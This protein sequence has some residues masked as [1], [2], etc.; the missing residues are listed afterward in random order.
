MQPRPDDPGSGDHRERGLFCGVD[1]GASATKVVLLDASAERV[2]RAVRPSG[3]DYHATASLCL[4]EALARLGASPSQLVRTVS[5]GYGRR[6]V[7]FA[8]ASLTEIHCHG[9]GCFRHLPRAITVIDIGGQDN[10]VIL[11]DAAGRRLDFKMNRKCAAGTGAFIEE[12]ALRLGLALEEMDGLAKTTSRAVQL[13]SFC[14]VFAKTEILA[15]LRAGVP[16]AE[17]VRG[18]FESVVTRVME[19]APL[20]G[21]VVMTGGV[22]AYNPTIRAVLSERLGRAVEVP[23][24]PQFTGALGAALVA[25]QQAG[26]G[27]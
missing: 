1:V 17:I 15:H 20:G 9:I 18:A 27:A 2:A 12:I 8:D 6:N 10:K 26:A 4:S 25:Y 24:H 14:T 7:G 5:T 23:P 21:E 16:V 22:V 19:M 13:S 11:L 3:V